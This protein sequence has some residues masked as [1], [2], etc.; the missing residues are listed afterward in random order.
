MAVSVPNASA[1]ADAPVLI[2]GPNEGQVLRDRDILFQWNPIVGVTSY[3]CTLDGFTQACSTNDGMM[4][5]NPAEGAHIFSV[6]GDGTAAATRNFT[7][8]RT[9][10]DLTITFGPAE[11][12]VWT[13]PEVT[14]EWNMESGAYYECTLDGSLPAPCTSPLRLGSLHSGLRTVT[15]LGQDWLGNVQTIRRTFT[16]QVTR[17]VKKCKWK[18]VRRRGKVVRTKRG[19]SKYRKV[20]R[21]VAVRI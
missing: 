18:K 16:A 11:G 7:I 8:D 15:I 4:Y 19:K 13:G 10:P 14:F 2:T 17:M 6:A 1:T 9:P 12:A 5:A 20:C 3:S 21:R